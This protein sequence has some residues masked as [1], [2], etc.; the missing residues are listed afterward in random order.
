MLK[1]IK[2]STGL[3]FIE[4]LLS[5][6]A[7]K[8]GEQKAFSEVWHYEPGATPLHESDIIFTNFF[9]LTF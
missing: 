2:T 4:N 1:Q 3:M 5:F 8:N 6:Y 9:F 7:T